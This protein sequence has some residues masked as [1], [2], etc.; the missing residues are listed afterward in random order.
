MNYDDPRRAFRN[1]VRVW[2]VAGLVCIQAVAACEVVSWLAVAV[3]NVVALV[4]V[5][6]LEW[7]FFRLWDSP[8]PPPPEELPI[9]EPYERGDE[10]GLRGEGDQRP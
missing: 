10:A 1:H 2:Y 4:A 9:L 5:F 6:L 7:M 3:I 8:P